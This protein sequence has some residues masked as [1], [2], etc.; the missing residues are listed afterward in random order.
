MWSNTGMCNW[1][2]K[3]KEGVKLP[4]WNSTTLLKLSLLVFLSLWLFCKLSAIFIFSVTLKN[5]KPFYSDFHTVVVFFFLLYEI[6]KTCWGCEATNI[7]LHVLDR[8]GRHNPTYYM[9]NPIFTPPL[10]NFRFIIYCMKQSFKSKCSFCSSNFF[11]SRIKKKEQ[12]KESY[13]VS[14]NPKDFDADFVL[15]NFNLC[16]F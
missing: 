2:W 10:V 16:L 1:Q 9:A 11:V 5:T 6:T 14:I 8:N 13:C 3:M 4:V 12:I 15:P 7:S